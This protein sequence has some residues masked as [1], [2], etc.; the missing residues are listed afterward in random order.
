ML[1]NTP[2][3]ALDSCSLM[4]FQLVM[5]GVSERALQLYTKCYCVASVKT[6][7]LKDLQII[8]PPTSIY[9]AVLLRNVNPILS[10][11]LGYVRGYL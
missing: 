11:W 10:V 3:F 8:H 2:S 7:L 6:F 9:V 4:K 1:L 5:Q